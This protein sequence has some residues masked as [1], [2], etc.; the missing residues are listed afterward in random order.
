MLKCRTVGVA[1]VACIARG[2]VSVPEWFGANGDLITL[3]SV[4]EPVV[5]FATCTGVMGTVPEERR[6]ANLIRP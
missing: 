1:A 2:V 5:L 3:T 6:T 4:T